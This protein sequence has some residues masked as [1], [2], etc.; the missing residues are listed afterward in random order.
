M[1][2]NGKIIVNF[3]Y[4]KSLVSN[5]TLFSNSY[6]L[7]VWFKTRILSQALRAWCILKLAEDI[8][9]LI[10]EHK[11][12]YI[13]Y[14]NINFRLLKIVSKKY[15][16]WILNNSFIETCIHILLLQINP[17]PSW[18]PR[19][20]YY[21]RSFERDSVKTEECRRCM[22]RWRRIFK[23]NILLEFLEFCR[24]FSVCGVCRKINFSQ[25]GFKILCRCSLRN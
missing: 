7:P 19:L 1:G 15:S 5:L 8:R 3:A 22:Y 20:F 13:Y 23:F 10:T 25:I 11:R 9:L 18:G 4:L 21:I 16:L 14:E 2:L 17:N 6:I 12:K 24:S